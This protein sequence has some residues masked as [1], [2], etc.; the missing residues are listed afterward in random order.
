M[1]YNQPYYGGYYQP[2][3]YPNGGAVPD[4]LNQQKMS[5]Q[6][7]M[8]PMT[9]PMSTPL[10]DFIWVLSEVEAQSY[11]V[12]PNN[13]VILWDKNTPTIYIKSANMQGVPTLRTLDFTERMQNAPQSPTTHEC[14]CNDKFVTKADFEALRSDFEALKGKLEK[15]KKSTITPKEVEND[16]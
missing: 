6:Q 8:Q 3:Y 11:P 4:M 1:A 7:Q 12:A 13:T 15:P 14:Q 9:Q 2:T 10:N 5:Y 16:G